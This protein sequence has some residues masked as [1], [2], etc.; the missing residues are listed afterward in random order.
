[1]GETSEPIRLVA[2]GFL[3]HQYVYVGLTRDEAV[4]R[5]DSEHPD[6]TVADWNH[7]VREILVTNG[8]FEVYD[9]WGS[10]E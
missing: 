5:H 9:I 2:I 6:A 7:S 1:M 8:C 10:G 4:K 3:G